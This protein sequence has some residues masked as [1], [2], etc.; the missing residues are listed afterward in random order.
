MARV[1]GSSVGLEEGF[2]RK[3]GSVGSVVFP[4][5]G[6]IMSYVSRRGIGAWERRLTVGL[7]V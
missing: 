5:A 4:L 3:E 2:F 7:S 6:L 1:Q